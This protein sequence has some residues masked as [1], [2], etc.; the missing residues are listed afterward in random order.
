MLGIVIAIVAVALSIVG[1]GIQL[2]SLQKSL[3]DLALAV[4]ETA[5]S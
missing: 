1:V 2:L 3:D 4:K 5:R